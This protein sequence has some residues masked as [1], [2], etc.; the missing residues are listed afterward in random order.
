MNLWAAVSSRL[1][2]QRFFAHTDFPP[3]KTSISRRSRPGSAPPFKDSRPDTSALMLSTPSTNATPVIVLH[4]TGASTLERTKPLIRLTPSDRPATPSHSETLALSS[5]TRCLVSC[6]TAP[7][8]FRIRTYPKR[9]RNP[10]RMHSFKTKDLKL[11]RMS[12][13]RKTGEGLPRL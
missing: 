1:A 8:P 13:Y 5:P 10:F 6:P 2:W 3:S 7:N 9:T 11:F 12:I 4:S